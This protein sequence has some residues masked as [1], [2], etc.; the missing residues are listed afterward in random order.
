MVWRITAS[1]IIS[2]NELDF[3]KEAEDALHLYRVF[4]FRETQPLH[5]QGA[6]GKPVALGAHRLPR[7]VP[8]LDEL[9]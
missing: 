2:R 8:A 4:Q 7:V 5:P 9:I 1:F 6:A 3:S